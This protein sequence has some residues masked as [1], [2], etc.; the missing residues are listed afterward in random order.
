[1]NDAFASMHGYSREEMIGMKVVN[2]H[3]EEQMDE[4]KK[5]M[6]QI[7]TQELVWMRQ[8]SRGSLSHSLPPKRWAGGQG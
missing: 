7:K 5:G 8:R 1:V 6:N 3:N 4:Y 2:L